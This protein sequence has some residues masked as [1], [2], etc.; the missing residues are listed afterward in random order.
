MV[1]L[2]IVVAL[3]NTVFII[4]YAQ[5]VMPG[6]SLHDEGRYDGGRYVV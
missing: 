3:T 5:D 2:N 4:E 6:V 1:V